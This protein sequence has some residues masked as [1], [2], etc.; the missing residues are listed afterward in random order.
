MA[1]D[2]PDRCGPKADIIGQAHERVLAAG[3][4]GPVAE[5]DINDDQNR[6][7]RNARRNAGEAHE[8][9]ADE[10]ADRRCARATRERACGRWPVLLRQELRQIWQEDR[11]L[12]RGHREERGHIGGDRHEADV[13]ER[14]HPRIAR[15]DIEA[16]DADQHDERLRH[17]SL[18]NDRREGRSACY[19]NDEHDEEDQG[20]ET[21]SALSKSPVH[22]RCRRL[23]DGKRPSGRTIR[24]SATTTKTNAS[25]NGRSPSGS[26][27]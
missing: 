19:Q 12:G 25:R 10:R 11:L 2:R 16:D 23:R 1:S 4:R 5:P 18:Q 14:E 8:R 9:E 20:R 3:D 15:E 26:R 24:T 22:M 7:R 27:A 6:E 17:A 21:R 13:A